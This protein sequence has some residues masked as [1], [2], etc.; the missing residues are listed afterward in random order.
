MYSRKFYLPVLLLTVS[1]LFSIVTGC[2]DDDDD[3]VITPGTR[4]KII[5]GAA[6]PLTGDYSDQGID[7]L[8]AARLAVADVNED[9]ENRGVDKELE[10]INFDTQTNP[11]YANIQVNNIITIGARFILG[12]M[13]SSEILESQ[14]VVNASNSLLISPSSTLATLANDDNIFRLVT[15]DE[16]MIEATAQTMVANGTNKVAMLIRYDIWGESVAE[17]MEEKIV[18]LGGD[19]LCTVPYYGIRPLDITTALDSLN[20]H[21]EELSENDELGSVAVQMISYDEGSVILDSVSS[22]PLMHQVKWYGCD[23]FVNNT[24]LF[25]LPGAAEFAAEVGFSS[26]IFGVEATTEYTDLTERIQQVTG[27]TPGV[28]P[29]ISY[30]AIWAAASV[31]EE[32]GNDA[33]LTELKSSLISKLSGH[34]GVSGEVSINVETG[35][36]NHGSYYFW[37]V[38]EDGDSYTWSHTSTYTVGG[39]S[40]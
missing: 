4:E 12:P 40:N 11:D 8:E 25:D 35:D 20:T 2:D 34:N 26:P 28:Y 30:D 22:Y 10:L 14:S 39:N 33:A 6:L 32:V 1:L 3:N 17:L 21:L 9:W 19:Y 36:R 18:E 27:H 37:T 5:I 31:L 24:T 15:D 38:V 29:I 7:N 13:T 16:A 23:G